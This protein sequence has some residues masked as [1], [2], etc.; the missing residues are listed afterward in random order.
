[1]CV[2][3]Y[4][5]TYV[6]VFVNLCVLVYLGR[7]QNY[8]HVYLIQNH[9]K[10][11]I[12]KKKAFIS[13]SFIGKKKLFLFISLLSKRFCVFVHFGFA[14]CA[15][16]LCVGVFVCVLNLWYI[17]VHLFVCV[18]KYILGFCAAF[19]RVLLT[20]FSIYSTRI[21]F[22]Y[23]FSNSVK[24]PILSMN[25]LTKFLNWIPKSVILTF[26]RPLMFF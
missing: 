5:V 3:E 15:D 1:M 17:N 10:D 8:R 18:C 16:F 12:F 6:W 22:Y 2:C 24:S 23:K 25:C 14:F 19:L 26:I 21:L 9:F 20:K 13:K 7:Q 4:V 11:K